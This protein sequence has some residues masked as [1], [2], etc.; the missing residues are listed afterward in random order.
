MA[1]AEVILIISMIVTGAAV[2]WSLYL[3]WQAYVDYKVLRKSGK[4]GPLK[5]LSLT[6]IVAESIRS[7]KLILL[8]ALLVM[9]FVYDP[10]DFLTL[11]RFTILAV[12]VLIATGSIYGGIA[13][14]ALIR[15][16]E[17]EYQTTYTRATELIPDAIGL[18]THDGE[19]TTYRIEQ[20]EN[21][22]A[23]PTQPAP[24]TE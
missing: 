6:A 7:V 1:S 3:L 17:A 20:V 13:R 18:G 22:K 23:L 21:P 11:R 24:E 8:Q 14:R 5:A 12:I 9:S 16:V 19:G 10:T 4:N 15:L 2:L